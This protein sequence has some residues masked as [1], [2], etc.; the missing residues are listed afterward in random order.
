M[1]DIILYAMISDLKDPSELQVV[2]KF[3]TVEPLAIMLSKDDEAYKKIVDAEMKRLIFS[4]EAYTL[5]QKWFEKPIPP[6]TLPSKL[7]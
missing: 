2:G 3:L 1:D 5:Y 6:R 7:L 4:K